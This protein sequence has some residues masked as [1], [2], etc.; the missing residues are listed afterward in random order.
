M[1]I[2]LI[3]L[4]PSLDLKCFADDVIQRR[5]QKFGVGGAGTYYVRALRLRN[6]PLRNER[7]GATIVV[8]CARPIACVSKCI[9]CKCTNM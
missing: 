5:R 7:G 1:N 3:D 9:E 4:I 6:L 2:S 8:V